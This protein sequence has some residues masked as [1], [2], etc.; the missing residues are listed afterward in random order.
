[1]MIIEML[2]IEMNEIYNCT[3]VQLIAGGAGPP[4]FKQ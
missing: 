2:A 1:M 3:R 4:L